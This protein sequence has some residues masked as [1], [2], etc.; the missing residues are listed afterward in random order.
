MGRPAKAIT[1]ASGARTQDEIRV[2]EQVEQ[3]I[4]SGGAPVPP[5]HLTEAQKEVFNE[6]VDGLRDADI[7]GKLDV[8]T[9]EATAVAIVAVRELN[10]M[11]ENDPQ[12]LFSRQLI[13]ARSKYQSEYWRGCNELC[14]SPQA[15]A[16]LGA[17]TAQAIKAK[18]D[19]LVK[20]LSMDD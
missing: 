2:R 5:E 11:I 3:S 12:L 8:Y 15:R 9:L 16:K 14:L 6:I 19:P 1:V 10:Q 4:K 7:L 20:A 18:E 13:G 17:V